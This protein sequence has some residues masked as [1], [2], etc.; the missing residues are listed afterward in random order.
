[1]R[2]R[3]HNI[4]NVL[5]FSFIHPFLFIAILV[6]TLLCFIDLTRNTQNTT[7]V[8]SSRLV[9]I[10]A[11]NIYIEKYEIVARTNTRNKI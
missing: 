5:L 11:N 9:K 3:D 10:R 6:I 2:T 7:F 4:L 8:E 1:M